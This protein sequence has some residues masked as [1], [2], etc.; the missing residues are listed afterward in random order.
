[1]EEEL[2]PTETPLGKDIIVDGFR[3]QVIGVFA[4]KGEAF[5][6]S[7]DMIALIPI[8]RMLAAY[9]A[10][11]RDLSI[12]VRAPNVEL[13]QT[14]M[15]EVTGHLRIIRRVRAGEDNNFELSSNE[16]LVE[17]VDAFASIVAMGGAGVGLITLLAAGIGIMNIMLVSV[18]ERTRE[19]GVR[20]AVGAKRNDILRRFLYEAIFLC[21][22][23]G[24]IRDIF[25]KLAP[26]H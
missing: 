1:V 11:N 20:K 21:Q 16:A 9:S 24:I 6:Q 12:S 18:T 5:G 4:E 23:G 22:I 19:I 14:T 15:D 17:Q 2:F 13:L 3:Y 25:R 10:S 26:V 8:T 7:Q